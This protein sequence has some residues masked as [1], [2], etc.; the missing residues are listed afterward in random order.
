MSLVTNYQH[1]LDGDSSVLINKLKPVIHRKSVFLDRDGVLIND[2]EHIVD[3][4]KVCIC[5]FVE[6]FLDLI[7]LEYNIIVV[8]NQSILARKLGT[9]R[10][11]LRVT[12]EML[13]F[14]PPKLHPNLILASF[15]HPEFSSSRKYSSWRK[16]LPGMFMYVFNSFR[17]CPSLSLMVGDK[18][19]DLQAA[20]SAGIAKL[21]HVKSEL[22][23]DEQSKVKLWSSSERCEIC[24]LES[25]G[26][27]R[28]P[29]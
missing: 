17:I 13:S 4:R 27:L 22:H 21:F 14:L 6:D 7:T 5:P 16:P 19:T 2:V 8:T 12:S 20:H 24:Y 28:L 9:I 26:S 23:S 10:D 29:L 1:T 25:L 11:Y 3:P 18:L 15:Y